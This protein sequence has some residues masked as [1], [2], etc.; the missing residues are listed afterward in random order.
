MLCILED[1]AS[2]AAIEADI[3]GRN[4]SYNYVNATYTTLHSASVDMSA[5]T[6]VSVPSYQSLFL[7]LLLGII[8]FMA[9][10]ITLMEP[11]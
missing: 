11:F 1:R 3:S 8:H 4:H 7:I 2:A 9:M 10:F 5:K 6:I